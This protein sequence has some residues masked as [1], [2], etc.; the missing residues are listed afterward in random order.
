MADVLL[1]LIMPN[2]V[3]QHVED[4]LLSRPDLVPGFT[5]SAAEGHGAVVPL[6]EDTELV[7]GHAPRTV[8]RTVGPEAA[9]REV[10]ALLKHELPRANIFYWLIPVIEAK[11]L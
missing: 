11:H 6:V 3:A 10:L 4:L 5:V 1:T 7:A 2:D 9:K 8:I